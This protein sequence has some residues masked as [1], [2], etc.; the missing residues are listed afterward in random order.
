MTRFCFIPTPLAGL[1][2]V[3]RLNLED[4]RGFLSK[5]FCAE[6][7]SAA[8]FGMSIAQINQTL[9]KRVG[10][11][12]GMHYQLPPFA[13]MKLVTCIR[14][15]IFD[16]AIDL[17]ANSPTFMRWH[18]EILSS[19]NRCALAIPPG[20]AHGF[21]TLE[22]NCELLY[23]HSAPYRPGEERAINA[24]DPRLSIN[25]PMPISEMSDRDRKHAFL[26]KDFT[27]V[28]V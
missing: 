13:E 28:V 23:I 11:V 15:R 24:I 20:F 5:L 10:T 19:D 21:Q 26:T 8:G 7:F 27:G 14:G 6:D 1:I 16:V 12:R 2:S 9:T 17:R 3:E 22:S 4:H 18:G 25:W